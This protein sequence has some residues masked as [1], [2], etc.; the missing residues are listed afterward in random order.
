MPNGTDIMNKK[1]YKIYLAGPDVFRPDAVEYGKSL[2]DMVRA[3]G[4]VP[5]FPSDNKFPENAPDLSKQ[6]FDANVAMIKDCDVVLANLDDFRGHEPDSGTAW[7]VG[8]AH[9]LGKRIIGYR[10]DGKSMLEKIADGKNID[11]DENGMIIEDFGHSLNLMLIHS[12]DY[13]IIGDFKAA[14]EQVDKQ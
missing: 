13:L 12:M 10:N 8:F 4:H 1:I 3:A 5:L 11:C 7:E 14:L 9:A 2:S 6:I